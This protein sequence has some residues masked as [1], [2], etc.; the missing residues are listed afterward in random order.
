[1]VDFPEF[2]TMLARTLNNR[3]SEEDLLEAFAVLDK[4]GSGYISVAELRHVMIN[5]GEKLSDQEVNEMVREI[6]VD[7]EGRINYRGSCH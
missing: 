7:G 4:E 6:D 3:E 1:M 5:L 2:L